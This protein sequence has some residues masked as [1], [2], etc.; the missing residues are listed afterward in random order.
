MISAVVFGLI[1]L[2][3]LVI[4]LIALIADPLW[5]TLYMLLGMIGLGL[6]AATSERV[7]AWFQKI[8]DKIDDESIYDSYEAAVTKVQEGISTGAV[9]VK[10]II[11]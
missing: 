5:S 10:D 4:A 1:T 9:K 11:A 2:V 3:Y 6:V 7:R 8:D